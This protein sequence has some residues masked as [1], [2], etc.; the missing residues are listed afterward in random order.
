M[1]VIVCDDEEMF[2]DAL[3]S[4][5]RHKGHEI[6]MVTTD[7]D[8]IVGLVRIGRPAACVL[9]LHF[10][11]QPRTDLVEGIAAAS[12][13]TGILLLTGVV[14][15]LAWSSYDSGLV[16][17]LASKG[18][19]LDAIDRVLCDVLAGRRAT[20]GVSRPAPALPSPEQLTERELEVLVLLARGASTREIGDAL[21]IGLSTARSHVQHLFQKLGVHSRVQAVRH[22]VA[23][24]LVGADS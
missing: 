7:P 4:A 15:P 19:T 14:A 12:P 24:G 17:G 6:D 18:C 8:A 21:D 1:S 13:H 16:L 20:A 9:D 2:A 22:A 10:G 3:A 11:G 5:L 23:E